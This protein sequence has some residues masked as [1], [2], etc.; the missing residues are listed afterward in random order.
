M[1]GAITPAS[2]A[3]ILPP[4]SQPAPAPQPGAIKPDVI[5][6]G[7]PSDV[8]TGELGAEQ[9]AELESLRKWFAN[10]HS[11]PEPDK[12]AKAL[13][14]LSRLG[15]LNSGERGWP[16]A[17]LVGELMKQH[18]DRAEEWCRPFD[19]FEEPDRYWF[20]TGV[21]FA[22][23]EQSKKALLDRADLPQDNP[24]KVSYK[25]VKDTP[26]S[27][28]SRRVSGPQQI[29]MLLNAFGISGKREYIDKLFEALADPPK[30]DPKISERGQRR[31]QRVIPAVQVA[32]ARACRVDPA[33]KDLCAAGATT[34]KQPIAGRIEEA[35]KKSEGTDPIP[36]A[37]PIKGD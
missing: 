29:E 5:I 24:R 9:K 7:Q 18:P 11:N 23:T 28:L 26:P 21:W 15:E 36:D 34:Q 27:I 16:A 2:L 14:D 31:L 25:W 12:V 3:Q 8:K 6:N 4:P 32:L 17:A 33:L 37:P 19:L 20:F 1:L 10:Y 13:A 30:D 35:L 22:A